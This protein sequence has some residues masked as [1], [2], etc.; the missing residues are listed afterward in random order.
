MVPGSSR[1]S[2]RL[3][4]ISAA[5]LL[6]VVALIFMLAMDGRLGAAEPVVDP[7]AAAI[8]ALNAATGNACVV[9][10]DRS[11]M[12]DPNLEARVG[13]AGGAGNWL[14]VD[15]SWI[16]SASEAVAAFD[17]RLVVDASQSAAGEIWIQLA[18]DTNRL[19]QLREQVTATGVSV[20]SVA[21]E[22]HSEDPARCKA[23]GEAGR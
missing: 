13:E 18:A 11:F 4:V 10:V 8:Q 17:A 3:Q 19:V 20:W 2:L 22:I 5:G 23:A 21:D 7:E 9:V 1:Q 12:A 15:A 14:E 6:I 16:G